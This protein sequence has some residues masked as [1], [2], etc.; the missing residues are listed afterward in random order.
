MNRER[1]IKPK[2]DKYIQLYSKKAN[3]EDATQTLV[4]TGIS[5]GNAGQ[6]YPNSGLTASITAP[7]TGVQA[8]CTPTVSNGKI[9]G[10]VLTNA[11]SGYT[12]V[13]QITLN[14]SPTTSVKAIEI[15]D[16]GL[17]YTSPPKI[18]IDYPPNLRRA[19]ITATF[20]Y[21]GETNETQLQELTIIDGGAG[22]T[23]APTIIIDSP[24]YESDDVRANVSLT[25]LNGSVVNSTILSRGS[26]SSIG[27]AFTNVSNP[28][29]TSV[30]TATCTI[31]GEGSINSITITNEGSGYTS[32][33]NVVLEQT[34]Y[35]EQAQL[36][37]HRTVGFNG[38]LSINSRYQPSQVFKYT[39]DL[40]TPISINENALLQ[41][42]ERQ[43][44]N[45]PSGDAN[46]LISIKIHDI[47][48]Q[49]IV[50]TRNTGINTDFN[51]GILLDIGKPDRVVPNDIKLEI[52]QEVINRITLSINHDITSSAGFAYSNEFVIVMKVSEKEPSI[53]EYG[54]LNNINFLQ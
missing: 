8:T 1:F 45:I 51:G 10:A 34:S 43:F 6:N 14:V 54:A 17:G 46:K 12:S 42:V 23:T 5:I 16:R 33:P 49:S 3:C 18:F 52:N 11:G 15:A 39:W 19:V 7:T 36:I 20:N 41:I 4:L 25:I 22:Y 32:T 9:T 30:A 24:N 28:P 53:I 38:A 13:P 35:T 26:Y 44:L 50:N 48:T 40:D 37:A 21:V 27:T 47:G 29:L 2:Y 31:D